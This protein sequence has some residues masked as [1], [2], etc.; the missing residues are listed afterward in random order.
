MKYVLGKEPPVPKEV[1]NTD[2]L[3]MYVA[4]VMDLIPKRGK[5][6]VAL[7]LLKLFVRASLKRDGMISIGNRLIKVKE[8]GVRVEDIKAWLDEKGIE[9]SLNQLYRTYINRFM[10][11]GLIEKKTGVYYGLRGY[12]LPSTID[13]IW[14][15]MEVVYRDLREHAHRLN[16][17]LR[18]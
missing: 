11:R 2:V 9:I 17:L 3:V 5:G 18:D 10:E 13:I 6:D 4:K 1:T 12:D 15:E 8:G 14:R 16:R 7:E